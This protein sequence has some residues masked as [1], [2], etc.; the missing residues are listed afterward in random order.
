[1]AAPKSEHY[2]SDPT[3]AQR[4]RKQFDQAVWDWAEYLTKEA[5]E[6]AAQEGQR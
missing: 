4:N 2:P 6:K 5:A 3:D 1:M